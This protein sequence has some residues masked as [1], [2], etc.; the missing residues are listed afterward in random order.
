M[1]YLLNR[2]KEDGVSVA[3]IEW[4]Q[5]TAVDVVQFL[6]TGLEARKE[7]EGVSDITRRRY[8]RLLQRIYSFAAERGWVVEN[9]VLDVEREDTPSSEDP[10]GAIMLE[11]L[12]HSALQIVNELDASDPVLARNKA[13]LLLLFQYGITPQEA[14]LLT[15]GAVTRIANPSSRRF[16]KVATVQL[17]GPGPNQRRRLVLTTQVADALDSWLNIRPSFPKAQTHAILFCTARNPTMS[18]D[19]LFALVKAIMKQAAA[20]SGTAMPVRMGPQVV[21]NTRL[22][23]W[24]EEGVPAAEVAMRAGLKNIKGLHHLRTHLNPEIRLTLRNMRD[25]APVQMQLPLRLMA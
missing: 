5:V 10:L 12:W 18:A 9:P 19:N 17:D 21:R 23:R 16:G 15:I 14:R 7:T 25:D 3:P 11:P 1:T 22:V 4:H 24:L 6:R 13:L 8:W 2:K 20:V